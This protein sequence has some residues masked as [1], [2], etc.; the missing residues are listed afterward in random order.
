[1]YCRQI[2]SFVSREGYSHRQHTPP[3]RSRMSTKSILIFRLIQKPYLSKVLLF[4][5]HCEQ[6]MFQKGQFMND[7]QKNPSKH[8][9]LYLFMQQAPWI[10]RGPNA[11]NKE[12]FIF[13]Q[14]S[15][16]PENLQTIE[17]IISCNQNKLGIRVTTIQQLL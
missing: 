5:F 8:L 4:L 12:E 6:I 1:M 11:P 3:N 17:Q 15:W 2:I 14:L 10:I 13:L 16:Q 7:I 9:F